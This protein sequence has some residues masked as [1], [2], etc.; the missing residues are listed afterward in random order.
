[1]RYALQVQYIGKNYAGSQIQFENGIEIQ[2]PTVQGELEKAISTLIFGDTENKNRQLKTVFSGRT[3]KGVNS[4]G[5][6][7]HFDTDKSIV[8]SKFVYQLNEILPPDISVSD[9]KEVDDKFHAQKSAKRRYY[10]FVFVNRKCKNAF[11]GDLMRVKYPVDIE[12]MQKALDFIKGEHDFSSFK[13]S[14]TLNPSKICFIEKATCHKDGDNVIIDIVGNRFLY[15]M[16]RTIVGT[17]LEIEGHKLPAEHME[18]VLMACDRRK[19]GQTV[20]PY[21]LTLMKVEYN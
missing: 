6:V 10:R 15:N 5:Q 14:G 2:T 8:A 7:I 16:V 12:R 19:A 13:S 11:D 1:M 18:Q 17:L 4:K 21:G 9:L 20:S 3:D